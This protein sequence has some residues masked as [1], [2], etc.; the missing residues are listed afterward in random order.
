M[1]LVVFLS[2]II[3]ADALGPTPFPDDSV[4]GMKAFVLFLLVCDLIELIKK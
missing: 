1:R 4:S 2:A 3:L